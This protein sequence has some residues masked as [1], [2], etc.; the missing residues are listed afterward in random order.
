MISQGK[1]LYKCSTLWINFHCFYL[2]CFLLFAWLFIDEGKKNK[3]TNFHQSSTAS[4]I[5]H[6]HILF[7]WVS[8]IPNDNFVILALPWVQLLRHFESLTTRYGINS[9]ISK[10]GEDFLAL[11]CLL[12]IRYL[13]ETELN[14][15]QTYWEI[16]GDTWIP[17]YLLQRN[18]S[19]RRPTSRT[20]ETVSMLF[21][22][23]P[24]RES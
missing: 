16:C 2:R 18:F 8:T 5:F 1:L 23:R 6:F 3:Q 7:F 19:T 17:G 24:N 20:G 15:P 12:T 21:S 9:Q 13:N 14:L 11:A 22:R 4:A 10:F